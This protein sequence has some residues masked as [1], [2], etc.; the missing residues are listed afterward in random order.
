MT[1]ANKLIK[2]TAAILAVA[3]LA[4][5][6]LY[7]FSTPLFYHFLYPFDR[8]AGTVHVTMNGEEYKLKSSDVTGQF[9]FTEE[10]AVRVREDADGASLSVHGGKYGPYSLIIRADGLNAPLEM[11]IYQYNWWNVTKFNMDISIDNAAE[12]ITFTS[13]A[14]VNGVT[15]SRSTTASFSDGTYKHFIVSV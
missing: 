2:T 7:L 9:D 12:T 11:V 8:I 3:V 15:E 1:T 14:K 6:I 4:S 13:T 5:G 10:I